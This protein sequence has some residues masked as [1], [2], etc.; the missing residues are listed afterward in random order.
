[1]TRS[2]PLQGSFSGGEFSP[3]LY[4]RVEAERYKTGL[5]VMKNYIAALQGP[6]IRRP[7]TYFVEETKDSSKASVLVRFE[8]S[9]T[10]AYIIEFGD[11][12]CRFYRNHGQ[13]SDQVRTVTN[14]TQANPAVV[15]AP[16]HVFQNG[17][18]VTLDTVVG[19][20]EVNGN[21]YTVANTDHASGTFELQGVDSTAYGAYVSGGT[22]TRDVAAP[23][24]VVTPYVEADVPK[25]RFTQSADVL[26]ITHPDYAP[27]TL[28]RTGHATWTLSTL[29]FEDGPYLITNKTS[30]TL[31]PS[32][33]T[34]TGITLTA[35]AVTG[36]NDDEGFKTT[37]VGRLIRMKQG[38]VWGW[39]KVT[40]WTSATVV[41]ADVMSTLT[42]TAAKSTWRLGVW[43]DTTG[44]PAVSTFYEDRLVF[45]GARDYPQRLD[46]SNS[47]DYVN[48]A[49]SETGGTVTNSH[50]ISFTL[51]SNTVNVVRWLSSDEKGLVAGTA[52][53]EWII[54]PSS[55]GEAL[56][57]TNVTGKQS[58]SHGS[59]DVAAV[60]MGK[61][62]LFAQRAG[63]KVRELKYFFG[64]DGFESPDLTELAEHVTSG[65]V[66]QFARQAE[67]R[68]LIWAL[69][70]DGVLACMTYERDVESLRVA[71][72]R[73]ILGGASDA[74]GADPI[75]E[76]IACIPAPTGDYDELWL[77]VR[78]WVNGASVRYI[79]Y[80]TSEFED[81]D[82][83]EDAFFVDCGLT[84]D[85]AP[86]TTVSGLGHLEGETVAILADGAVRPNAVVTSGAITLSTAASKIHVGYNY[87]SDGQLLRLDA[88]ATD[89]TS[90]GKSR[91]MY[92]VGM[93]LHRS[94]GLR[95][96]MSFDDLDTY[97]F[98]TSSDESGN[99]PH[100]FSG[101]VSIQVEA[102]YD[103]D[104]QFCWRQDQP[105][106]STILAICPRMTTQSL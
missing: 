83:Q 46:G 62:T 100:L 76:S 97:T 36:I 26:Y 24:E 38:S 49:P 1:M 85:G 65:G 75:V 12:Y 22:A 71:W 90:L 15:S 42:S 31:T 103:Y 59:A 33:A 60:S 77:L 13:I 78:R 27:R 69:R 86:T 8:F 67:P 6:A 39:V 43:S 23:Y 35:S 25:L 88:G 79:E 14:I 34:G 82:A 96:G 9:V 99:P 61:A 48:M 66:V 3:L 92:Y 21:S 54:R 72:S 93:L 30:T 53:G 94:L 18:T 17:I 106:P 52:G 16:G 55:T 4:G 91:R 40:G 10:Q 44:Y 32:A 41:T 29:V 58:T 19:M 104:N 74:N 57:P 2:A 73:Q 51:N 105:L 98:R 80:L 87:N 37:D 68:S 101:M 102:D 95:T 84:Y 56:S 89:G 11:G 7:G 45:A 64:S 50:A 47:G 20:T 81:I 63:R 28:S 70:G 5:A